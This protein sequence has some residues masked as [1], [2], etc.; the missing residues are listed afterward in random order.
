GLWDPLDGDI[1]PTSVTN[2][3][4]R[5][6]RECGVT[7]RRN[8]PV[9]SITRKNSGRWELETPGGTIS[10]EII[11]NAAGFRAPEIAAMA[12]HPIPIA[13]MEHQYLVTEDIPE[14][15]A[16]PDKI[17]MVRDPDTSYYLRHEREG[18]IIGPYEHDGRLWAVDGVPENFGQELLPPDLDRIADYVADA[19]ERVPLAADAGIKTIVNGPITYTPDGLPLIG[20]VAGID[21]CFLNC[22]SSFGITQGGGSGKFAAE[23]ILDG[24]TSLDMIELDPRRFADFATPE[25]VAARCKDIYDNEYAVGYPNEYAMRQA[26]RPTRTMPAHARHQAAGAQFYS[27]YGWERP[28]WF[29]AQSE[30]AETFSFRRTNAFDAIGRECRAVREAAGLLDLSPFAK[31]DVTGPGAEAFLDAIGGNRMPR[32]IGGIVLTHALTPEGGILSEF[33]V[34]RLGPEHFYVVSAA[35]AEAHDCDLLRQSL[36]ADGSVRIANITHDYG[37]LVLAGPRSRDILG[38]LTAADLSSDAFPWLTSQEIQAAGVSVRALR[39][40]F[41][42]ELGW[43]LHHLVADQLAIYDA[44]M[45]AGA[46]HGLIPFGMRAM[47]SLRLEKMYRGWRTDLTTEYSLVEAGMQRFVRF[48]KNVDFTGRE[49]LADQAA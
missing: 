5:D 47:D 38:R 25:W 39:V 21:N 33:T 34:T 27:A 1:D 28:A 10:A 3:M 22:G 12:G 14:L 9:M 44:L 4:A 20:P 42:G 48:D 40:N 6:A 18:I 43:E 49:A 36:P 23:W 45:Q 19:L 17:A 11:V 13:S 46:E 41:V 35:A 37:T 29:A 24:H 32:R 30:A 26:G 31:F 2:A 15:A 16:R 8:A 7:I